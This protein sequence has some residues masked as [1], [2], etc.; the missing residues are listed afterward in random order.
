[1][2][3]R[4]DP[5]IEV[6]EPEV[7]I[8]E[9]AETETN[10]DDETDQLLFLFD[11]LSS[12]AKRRTLTKLQPLMSSTMLE[13]RTSPEQQASGSD[14]PKMHTEQETSRSNTQEIHAEGNA[15]KIGDS[16]I[17]IKS[18]PGKVTTP[19]LRYFSGVVPVPSGQVN[20]K[21]WHSAATRLCKSE[22]LTEEEKIAR[23]HN[24]LSEP[25]LD[26]AQPALDSGSSK[27]IVTLLQTAFGCVEDPRDLL[28]AFNTTVMTSKESPSDYL[29]RLQQKVEELKLQGAIRCAEGPT[30]LIRQFNYGCTDDALILKLR[31]EEKEEDPPDYG[32]LLLML[33]KEEAKRKKRQTALKATAQ[34][35][36]VETKDGEVKQL[37]KEIDE[38][39]K[40]LDEVKSTKDGRGERKR[41][42]P[43]ETKQ[44]DRKRLRFCFRCGETGHV[45]WTCS[46]TA[47]PDAVTKRFEEARQGN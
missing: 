17:I 43:Q 37:R 24:S 20:F 42:E 31:L 12:R 46:N 35:H 15:L 8:R 16:T 27:A 28:N 3:A 39:S 10:T 14:A 29:N 4:D 11:K 44:K 36:L 5:G 18:A 6:L 25:A 26:I 21:T 1:M 34:Q 9:S 23:I 13:N 22:E 38:L 47:N 30:Y 19:K 2:A 41:D 7:D 45:V 40:K 32:T 33:R